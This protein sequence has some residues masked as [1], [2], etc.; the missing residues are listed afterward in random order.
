MNVIDLNLFDSSAFLLS[1][2]GEWLEENNLF[3]ANPF[4]VNARE[5]IAC[6]FKINNKNPLVNES[7]E[8]SDEIIN[9]K[10][11]KMIDACFVVLCNVENGLLMLDKLKKRQ[12][13]RLGF[14]ELSTRQ[15]AVGVISVSNEAVIDHVFCEFGCFFPYLHLREYLSKSFFDLI[16][17]IFNSEFTRRDS[18][19]VLSWFKYKFLTSKELLLVFKTK[20][21]MYIE[22][23]DILL[24]DGTRLGL[25]T[26]LTSKYKKQHILE[27]KCSELIQLNCAQNDFIATLGHEIRT[28]LNAVLGLIELSLGRVNEQD[29]KLLLVAF[30]TAKQVL[31]LINSMLDFRKGNEIN[32]IIKS[33]SVDVRALGES[34]IDVFSL[35]ASKKNINLDFYMP[36]GF[37]SRVICD[38]V[39]LNQVIYNLISNAI[40]FSNKIEPSILLDVEIID[41]SFE[42]VKMKF[43]VIDNGIGLT[44]EEQLR[45]FGKYEQVLS[46]SHRL[47]GGVGLGLYISQSICHSMGSELEVVSRIGDG[48]VFYFIVE[49]DVDDSSIALDEAIFHRSNMRPPITSYTNS[50]CFHEAVSRYSNDLNFELLFLPSHELVSFDTDNSI[51]FVDLNQRDI[52]SRNEFIMNLFSKKERVAELSNVSLSRSHS[53]YDVISYPPLKINQVIDFV[54]D[55]NK[56]NITVLDN[57]IDYSSVS[58]LVID[59]SQDNLFVI[60]KQLLSVGVVVTCVQDPM[61]AIELFKTSKFNVIISDV[62]MPTIYGPDLIAVIRD[63]ENYRQLAPSII[64][65]LTAEHGDE[66]RD[67][68][69]QAGANS[70]LVKP[71]ALVELVL[72]LDDVKMTLENHSS[73]DIKTVN[74]DDVS[75]VSD[76]FCLDDTV[77]EIADVLQIVD[78]SAIYKFV[79]Q[80]VTDD[81]L[82]FFLEQ[83]YSNLLVKR[84]ALRTAIMDNDIRSITAI[85]HT[86]KSNSLYV[87]A[88][89]L[90]LS[91][92][93]LERV[94]RNSNVE[95]KQL[96]EFWQEVDDDLFALSEFFMRRSDVRG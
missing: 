54:N 18:S 12:F 22:Y 59:D 16:R 50:P 94:S 53:D 55:K 17:D 58:V 90:N 21:G 51:L 36:L 85:S 79:G 11:I 62:V 6:H 38:E 10:V 29:R 28:P 13:D 82:E 33:D 96:L 39:R 68:C 70:V 25:L 52:I 26:D 91:C 42:N 49:F 76:F 8:F 37:S 15:T 20:S 47:H 43:S 5:S 2:E 93:E 24:E 9:F 46:G 71:L 45:I 4:L 92:Q 61:Q 3:L 95:Y 23:R 41:Q 44:Q 81:E 73:L 88:K 57:T 67:E 40:K 78:F 60:E 69:V 1:A 14:D 89:K 87:G 86:L 56:S 64:V 7:L 31:L 72:F 63:I 75:L 27:E 32:L 84:E 19:R 77:E 48:S 83:Y 65:M 30:S 80:D 66:C 34:I 35:Q 74:N